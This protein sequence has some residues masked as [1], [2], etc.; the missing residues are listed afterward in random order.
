MVVAVAGVWVFD[1]RAKVTHEVGDFLLF[2]NY[3]LCISQTTHMILAFPEQIKKSL[4]KKQ[5][6]SIGHF[7]V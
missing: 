1:K 5:F 6:I 7:G 2:P 4:Q 3:Y